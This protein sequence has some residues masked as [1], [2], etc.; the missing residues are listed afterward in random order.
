MTT[1]KLPHPACTRRTR[2]LRRSGWLLLTL[3]VSAL[4][5][6]IA[7]TWLSDTL[8]VPMPSSPKDEVV[9]ASLHTLPPPAP[10]PALKPAPRRH[11]HHKPRARKTPPPPVHPAPTTD[12]PALATSPSDAANDDIAM[13]DN[14]AAENG[15]TTDVPAQTE[16]KQDHSTPQYKIDLPPSVTLEYAVQKTVTDG[17]P[18]YGHGSIKWQTDGTHYTV[19]GEAGVLFFTVLHFRSE[20]AIDEYGV[21]PELYSEKRFRKSETATH[22]QRERNMISFSA[23]TKTYPRKGGEQDRGSVIW[24]LAGIGRGDSQHF[25]RGATIEMVVAGTRDADTWD[26]VVVGEEAIDIAGETILTWHV[27][28]TPRAGSY[29]QKLD[30]WLAPSKEWYPLRLRYTEV[31]GDMLDMSLSDLNVLERH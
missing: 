19:D 3:L 8:R 22:F 7:I 14:T 27:T 29:D 13:G 9:L 2:T 4:L 10:K 1:A 28:R 5:H 11:I 21:S 17:Q 25:T 12:A 18:M 24:Q 20:G 30:I 23:S 26:M 31:N 16:Q 15:P 6:L